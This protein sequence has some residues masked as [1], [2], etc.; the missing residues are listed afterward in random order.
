MHVW[1]QAIYR[2]QT[3]TENAGRHSRSCSENPRTSIATFNFHPANKRDCRPTQQLT[4]RDCS[5]PIS[6]HG[7]WWIFD[8]L[9]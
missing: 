1:L 3:V 8:C 6:I 9:N 7:S 2:R 4:K 5:T